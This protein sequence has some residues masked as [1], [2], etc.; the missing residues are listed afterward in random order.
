MR[1]FHA[2]S[3]GGTVGRVACTDDSCPQSKIDNKGEVPPGPLK[4][5]NEYMNKLN[6]EAF[7]L[8]ITK[9]IGWPPTQKD[10]NAAL[11]EWW[12]HAVQAYKHHYK[13][14]A[15]FETDDEPWIDSGAWDPDVSV[16]AMATKYTAKDLLPTPDERR[17]IR[18]GQNPMSWGNRFNEAW[19]ANGAELFCQLGDLL[20]G[21][22][23]AGG[24]DDGPEKCYWCGNRRTKKTPCPHC[25]RR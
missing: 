4:D 8:G 9:C 14:G 25:G 23:A 6:T 3:Y 20:D 5:L 17:L 24:N 7:D 1:H 10:Y 12:G 22:T 16:A 15:D 13:T 2:M 21:T 19:Q 11:G 18:A